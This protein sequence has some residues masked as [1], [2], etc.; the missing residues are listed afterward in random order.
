LS[1]KHFVLIGIL[2]IIFQSGNY[3]CADD[4]PEALRSYFESFGKEEKKENYDRWFSPDKGYHVIGSII[5]TTLIGQISLRGFDNSLEKSKTFG[6][7]ATFTLGIAKEI[8]D[9][10][11]PKNYFSWKDLAANGVGVIIGIIYW[12]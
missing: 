11:R 5:S 2:S 8:Y 12:V 6:A 4:K 1:F 7:G 10:K 3:L 9:S